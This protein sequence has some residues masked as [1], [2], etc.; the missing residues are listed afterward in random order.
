MN[1]EAICPNRN[2]LTWFVIAVACGLVLQSCGPTSNVRQAE[3]P[4]RITNPSSPTLTLPVDEIKSLP[5]PTSFLILAKSAFGPTLSI[6]VKHKNGLG[7]STRFVDLESIQQFYGPGD[8]AERVKRAIATAVVNADVRYVLLVGDGG[9]FPVRHKYM[10]AGREFGRPDSSLGDDWWLDGTYTPADHYYA[11]LFHHSF[12]SKFEALDMSKF[13]NWDDNGNGKYNEQVWEWDVKQLEKSNPLNVVTY[14]P[15][16]VDAYPD[17]ALGRI[18][19]H[20]ENDLKNYVD[21]DVRYDNGMMLSQ[22]KQGLCLLAGG[23]YPGSDGLLDGILAY[24]S[25][26]DVIGQ[27]HITKFGFNYPENKRQFKGTWEP[28]TFPGVRNAVIFNWGLVYLGHGNPSGWDMSDLKLPFDAN[29]VAKYIGQLS[30]PVVFGIGC[31]T[32]AFMPTVPNGPYLGV[33]SDSVWYY[34]FSH[35]V[36]WKSSSSDQTVPDPKHPMKNLP[37]VIEGPG[38]WD[39]PNVPNRTFACPWLF[40]KNEGGAI[41][42]FGETVV[43]EDYHGAQLTERVLDAYARSKASPVLLGDIWL[44]GQRKYWNDFKDDT[45]VF[46]NPRNYLCIMTFFGDPTLRLPDGPSR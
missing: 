31:E 38:T 5:R 18:P 29:E 12:P 7:I 25:L 41:A 30:L 10:N 14:N 11:S 39:Y 17:I 27:D 32:G 21:K 23:S 35:D 34:Q 9:Q 13:D 37:T 26:G 3:P 20:D 2:N 1:G 40:Q 42:Y 16:K 28:G 33:Y 46:H 44:Q 19:V 36:I 22:S 8:A 4:R 15:D 24:N 6:L 43:C 45:G